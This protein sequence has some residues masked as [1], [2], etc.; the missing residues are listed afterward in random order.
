MHMDACTLKNTQPAHSHLCLH[1]SVLSM[2]TQVT[3]SGESNNIRYS[4]EPQ[5]L[6]LGQQQYDRVLESELTIANQGK[7]PFVY[8]INT[9]LLSR[10][11]VIT[12]RVF[13]MFVTWFVCRV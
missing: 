6:D 4:V 5:F 11:S 8:S 3:M 2:P 12:V 1:L 10:P 13:V 7:V 9:R